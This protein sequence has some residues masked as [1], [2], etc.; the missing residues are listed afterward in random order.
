MPYTLLFLIG[1]ISERLLSID[2][3]PLRLG[4]GDLL[5]LLSLPY[6]MLVYGKVRSIFFSLAAFAF[7][8]ILLAIIFNGYS[9]GYNSLVT[10]PLRIIAA[11]VVV[12]ELL[13]LKRPTLWLFICLFLFCLSL[14]LLMF[15]SDGSK[16][17]YATLFNRNELLGYSVV[18]VVLALFASFKRNEYVKK[19]IGIKQIVL[20]VFLV[21]VAAL[22]QSRQ[23][24]LALLVGMVVLFMFLPVRAK[25]ISI[26]VSVVLAWALVPMIS[27]TL[28]ENERYSAKLSTITEFEPATRSDKYRLSNAIQAIDGFKESPLF[29][30]G[31]TSFRRN[32]IYNKVSHSTPLTILYE[33][34]ILGVSFIAVVFY[35]IIRLPIELKKTTFRQSEMVTLASFMPVIVTQ[36]FF[37]DLLSKA[38]LYVYLGVSVAAL[39]SIR[40]YSVNK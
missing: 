8:V 33:L 15:F 21:C 25:V 24:I 26:L 36:S 28:S 23:N 9:Y 39:V 6:G 12:N 38:P 3:G 11:G 16:L 35:S 2:V 13:R 19:S 22:L 5:I 17:Q 34:G 30:N 27:S 20:F 10:V 37:I 14:I 32:N 40:N 31:P 7:V 18:L 1:S 4:A 29:G